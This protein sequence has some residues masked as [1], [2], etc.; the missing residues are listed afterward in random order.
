MAQRDHEA[1]GGARTE[2]RASGAGARAGRTWN[3][4]AIFPD[5]DAWRREFDALRAEIETIEPEAACLP[6]DPEHLVRILGRVFDI[7]RRM[8]LL[9]TYAS[10]LADEDV[11]APA[12][13]AMRQSVEAL[14]AEVSARTSW[15]EPAI[16]AIPPD[17]LAAM[18]AAEPRLSPY[19]RFLERLERRRPHVLDR[20]RE[21]LLG[22]ATL[23]RGTGAT[24]AGLLRDA[25][26]PWPEI[27]L[28]DGSRLRL[29]QNGYARV[30][31]LAC[32]EDRERGFHAFYDRLGDFRGSLGAAIYG[33]VKEHVFEARVR[34][35]RDS[36]EAALDPN[37]IPSRLY[38]M[39]IEEIEHAIPA[40]HRYFA[41]RR[42][43]LGLDRLAYH[44]LHVPLTPSIRIEP[45]WDE[46]RAITLEALQPLGADYVRRLG[47]ALAGGW[48]HVDPA[49]SKR[50]GAYVNYGAY[51]VHPYMLLNHQDDYHSLSTLAHESGHLMHSLFSQEHQPYPTAHYTVFVA[52]VASTVNEIL[53]TWHLLDRA[54]SPESR[55]GLL[56]HMLDGIRGTVFRQTLFAKFELDLHRLVERGEA[57]TGDS[58]SRHYLDLVRRYHGADR[59]IVE[60]DERYAVEW[61]FVPHFHYN[62]YVYQYAT[63]FIAA[64][65]LADRLRAGDEATR[66][67]YRR[68]LSRGSAAPPVELLADAGVDM[69]RPEPIRSTIARMEAIMDSV[70][71]LLGTG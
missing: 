20:A 25:E 60:I 32:R 14:A 10:L 68:F 4:S 41:L 51:G 53:L 38:E 65:E 1:G 49:P 57:L 34:H 69:S 7:D 59:D 63:S 9:H 13:R 22:Q 47:Q 24:I 67:A 70:E 6:A 23:I 40:L 3:V 54:D 28:S 27:E 56:G 18:L 71:Q 61:A 29:D 42:R 39:L 12:P 36:L 11:S 64:M 62:F 26:L 55:L 19:R 46:A 15:V 48:V 8:N 43:C 33:T 37:E 2:D 44:D 17:K 30:R 31:V 50:S 45:D 35:Y 58:L 52:E 21:E 16:L 5:Q 66:R